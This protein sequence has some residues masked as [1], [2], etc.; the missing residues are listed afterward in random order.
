MVARFDGP[1]VFELSGTTT[2]VDGAGWAK[3]QVHG[4]DALP[5]STAVAFG[6]AD[7]DALAAKAW[8]ASQGF[9]GIMSAEGGDEGSL[10]DELGVS[11]PDDLATLLGSNLLVALDGGESDEL[12]VGARI[13]TDVAAANKVLDALE[14]HGNGLLVPEFALVRRTV[15]DDLVVAATKAQA[16]RLAADGALSDDKTFRSALPDL[17]DAALALWVDPAGAEAALGLGSEPDPDLEPLDGVGLTVSSI[18]D[19]TAL[20]P[21][22]AGGPLSP[23]AAADEVRTAALVVVCSV[24]VALPVGPGLVAARPADAG[25]EAGGRSLPRRR[26]GRRVGGRRRRLVRGDHAGRGRRRRPCRLP[27]D[28]SRPGGAARGPGRGGCSGRWPPGSSVHLLGPGSL[29]GHR[30]R[31][32]ARRAS[33]TGRSTSRRTA[34]CWPGR[35]PR[36]SPTSRSPPGPRPATTSSR[37]SRP[38]RAGT[39]SVPAQRSRPGRADPQEVGRRQPD[40]QAAAAGRDVDRR[41]PEHRLVD[42]RRQPAALPE[43]ADAADDVAG[44]PLGVRE[45]GHRGLLPAQGRGQRLEVQ[46]AGHRHHR[47]DQDAVD[48]GHQRLEHLVLRQAERVGRLT[49]VRRGAGR[50]LVRDAG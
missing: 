36:S 6:L 20:V 22:P 4:M 27:A 34:C 3:H 39:R 2:G 28:P 43:R 17:D 9:L 32:S 18:S 23:R 38:S 42:H 15:G 13:T 45:F 24:L 29:A 1:D 10:E 30:G 5:A 37:P 8:T 44:G 19:G 11:M 16:D 47:R 12:Q 41:E 35:W 49:A 46:A 33:S 7:G 40:L 48:P 50:V 21:A 26:R 14:S 31:P 25:R